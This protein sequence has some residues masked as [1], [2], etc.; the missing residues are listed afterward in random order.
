MDI[1]CREAKL[2]M[3]VWKVGRYA[4]TQALQQTSC[5]LAND[6]DDDDDDDEIQSLFGDHETKALPC[7]VF[8]PLLDKKRYCPLSGGLLKARFHR[9]VHLGS[10]AGRGSF[11]AAI[12]I[13][14]IRCNVQSKLGRVLCAV[15]ATSQ[16]ML[17]NTSPLQGPEGTDSC[18]LSVSRSALS[19]V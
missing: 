9:Q 19:F 8:Y 17:E 16:P 15:L 10:F 14:K 3:E 13:I 12:A 2:H 7:A 18:G 4:T 6:A 11:S 5:C 1:P